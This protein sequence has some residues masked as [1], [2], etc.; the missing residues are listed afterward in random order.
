MCH[1]G[2][3]VGKQY[4][5]NFSTV[6]H[7]AYMISANGGTWSNTNAEFNNKVRAFKFGKGDIVT[8]VVNVEEKK[9]TF[10]KKLESFDIPFSVIP[11][12]ELHPCALFYYVNDEVEYLPEYKE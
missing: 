7:G 10:K 4:Q 2:V 12:D 3:V 11:G 8:A 6:G 9:I 5:F 1:K